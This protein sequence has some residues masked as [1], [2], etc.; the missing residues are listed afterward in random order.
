MV[1]LW[2]E[3]CLIH[4]LKLLGGGENGVGGTVCAVR[5]RKTDV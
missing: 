4:D 5:L 1:I 2:G 3:I